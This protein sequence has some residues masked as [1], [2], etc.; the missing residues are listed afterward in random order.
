MQTRRN[1]KSGERQRR[2]VSSDFLWNKIQDSSGWQNVYRFFGL[3]D[4]RMTKNIYRHT[5]AL[6][7]VSFNIDIYSQR[8]RPWNKFR[9]TVCWVKTQPTMLNLNNIDSSPTSWVQN[10][11]TFSARMTRIVG[12]SQNLRFCSETFCPKSL[13]KKKNRVLPHGAIWI[14]NQR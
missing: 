13:F 9:V 11:D 8:N 10:D 4:L 7:E 5:E 2:V 1:K 3:S 12:S 14:C 6:A